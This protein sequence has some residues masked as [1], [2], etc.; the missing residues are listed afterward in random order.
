MSRLL[1]ALTAFALHAGAF[2]H[3]VDAGDLHIGHP[4]ARATKPGQ[5]TG[6]AYLSIENKGKQED[7]LLAASTPVAA[8][9]QVHLTTMDGNVARMREVD[10]VAIA[11]GAKVAMHP[12]EPGYHFMLIGLK[13]PLNAGEKF[14]LSLSFE[15][16]GK[17][18]VTVVVED[19]PAESSASASAHQH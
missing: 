19:K 7:K 14:P 17:V 4:F 1:I 13:Q 10:N 8:S 2:A 6:A 9:T 12:G 18:T 5:P 15:K 11:P 16:A 3:S